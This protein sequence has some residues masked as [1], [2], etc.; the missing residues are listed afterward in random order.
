MKPC[1]IGTTGTAVCLVT[2]E[3]TALAAGS[4]SLPVLAT[5]WLVAL[6]EEAACACVAPYLEE[7][8]TTVGTLVNVRHTA[9]SAI[10]QTVTAEA[11]LVDRDGRRLVFRVS[12]EDGAGS[13]GESVHERFLVA[14]DRFME[15]AKSRK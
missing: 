8:E 15:K 13:V 7:G 3:K 11:T 5:P 4:G 9:A 10:G 12:A 1:E 14:A 6:M 2:E